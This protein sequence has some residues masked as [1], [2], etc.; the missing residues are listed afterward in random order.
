MKINKI[1][2]AIL[3]L[4]IVG[5]SSIS[6]SISTPIQPEPTSTRM[7][8][9][10]NTLQPTETSSN[11]T[12]HSVETSLLDEEKVILGRC[13]MASCWWM[14]VDETEIIQSEGKDKL[15]KI[16]DK[17]VEITQDYFFN[18]ALVDNPPENAQ[19]I[20]GYLITNSPTSTNWEDARPEE[21]FI[22]CSQKLPAF[23]SHDKNGKY[24]VEIIFDNNGG[25]GGP[26]EG[27]GNLY[28]YICN[29]KPS[30]FEI[31]NEVLDRLNLSDYLVE[32][33]MDV[34]NLTK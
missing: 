6:T 7:L 30:K 16:C 31:S 21:V 23:I 18:P 33:P 27:V 9:P 28:S 15:V 12:T 11:C 3:V 29:G 4:F 20:N 19:R 26:T 14:K 5:C 17:V 32:K 34:F 1:L 24:S 22:F 8:I 25:T 13:H 2:W 10:T